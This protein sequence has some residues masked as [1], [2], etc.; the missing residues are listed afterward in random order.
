[1]RSSYEDCVRRRSDAYRLFLAEAIL[2]L[3]KS[4]KSRIVDD[5]V[6]DVYWEIENNGMHLDVPDFCMDHHVLGGSKDKW[7]EDGCKLE[8]EA[9]LP[10]PYAEAARRNLLSGKGLP[11]VFPTKHG[12]R[13]KKKK[14]ED[15]KSS[16]SQTSCNLKT[17]CNNEKSGEAQ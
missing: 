13:K 5:L 14:V 16:S 15:K 17:F 3:C 9:D 12:L 4:K 1:M 11:K 6:W 10:N 8:N 2:L 7:I